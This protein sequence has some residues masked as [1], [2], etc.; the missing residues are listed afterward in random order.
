[1][2]DA[3]IPNDIIL[4]LENKDTLEKLNYF[5]EHYRGEV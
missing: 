2:V 4:G 5:I 3:E 1:M